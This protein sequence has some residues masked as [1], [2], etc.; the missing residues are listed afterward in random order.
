MKCNLRIFCE[1]KIYYN[2]LI[3]YCFFFRKQKTFITRPNCALDRRTILCLYVPGFQRQVFKMLKFCRNDQRK[4]KHKR[5]TKGASLLRNLLTMHKLNSL[6]SQCFLV[7]FQ[8]E[9]IEMVP[10]FF[11]K[12]MSPVG[13]I[14]FFYL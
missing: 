10:K 1:R 13:W 11:Q 2:I 5:R 8:I 3:D 4:V 7:C 9:F 12:N 14:V 6:A